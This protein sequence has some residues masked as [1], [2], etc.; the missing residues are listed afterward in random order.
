ITEPTMIIRTNGT[1][2][3]LKT[4][5][6]IQ[7][8]KKRAKGR[9]RPVALPYEKMSPEVGVGDYQLDE[10]CKHGFQTPVD[11]PICKGQV[12]ERKPKRMVYVTEYGEVYHFSMQCDALELGQKK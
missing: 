2:L 6:K 5:V 4:G 3:N 11:C 10:M 8:R 12:E 1:M 9:S 7:T